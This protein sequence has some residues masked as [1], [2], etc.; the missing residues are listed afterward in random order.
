MAASYVHHCKVLGY[1]HRSET[2]EHFP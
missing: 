1:M 2:P